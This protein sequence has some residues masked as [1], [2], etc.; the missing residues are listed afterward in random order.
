MKKK[1]LSSMLFALLLVVTACEDIDRNEIYQ[2]EFHKILHLQTSGVIDLTLY[3]TGENTDYS[4]SIVKAGAFPDLTADVKLESMTSEE[5]EEYCTPRG[6]D[7]KLLPES[8]YELSVS[9]IHFN[10]EDRYKIINMSLNTTEIDNM[11]EISSDYVVPIMLKSNSDSINSNMNVLIIR[12]T[13]VIPSIS[14]VEK[15]LVTHYCPTGES[16]IE[17]PL[18]LQIENKWDFTCQVEIDPTVTDYDI[19]KKGYTLENQGIVTFTKGSSSATLKARI[20]RKEAGLEAIEMSAPVLPL[21][22][23]SVSNPSFD[24]DKTPL[25]LEVSSKYP[26]TAT[27]LTT[28][29]QEPSEGP[30][31][32]VLDGSVSTFFHSAWSITISDEHYVQVNLPETINSFMFSYTNRSSNGNAALANFNVSIS[33]D[34]SNFTT[35]KDFTKDADGLPG[36]AAGVYNSPEMK[37][38]TPIKSIRFTCKKN[39]TGEAY[40]VWSEFS[41]YGL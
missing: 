27:M 38:T 28:N 10:S 14:F 32:N 5:L 37:S 25:L 22:L 30:L 40:F 13:V 11:P 4:F 34:G 17:I 12:P 39:W 7:M 8:C 36:T 6:L 23:K 20:N 41:L 31:A 3:K 1:Y 21:R 2:E 29:A 18:E 33:Q 15:G 16:T 26:L 19:L 9:D 24:V 35:L